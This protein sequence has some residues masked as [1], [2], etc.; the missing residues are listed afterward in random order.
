MSRPL[1]CRRDADAI[2]R[3][4]PSKWT[5][6]WRK[7]RDRSSRPCFV[8]RWSA[9]PGSR[10][11]LRRAAIRALPLKYQ[12]CPTDQSSPFVRGYLSRLPV[13][14][15]GPAARRG[16]CQTDG[17]ARQP[18]RCPRG[19]VF[20]DRRYHGI[21][22]QRDQMA[23]SSFGLL[24][25]IRSNKYMNLSGKVSIAGLLRPLWT[26]GLAERKGFEPSIHLSSVAVRN[27]SH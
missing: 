13:G 7:G 23:P 17:A 10:R 4:S 19:D 20:S 11:S 21:V 2:F 15:Y 12:Q 9:A 14:F 24:R 8:S 5:V 3:N 1:T 27:R 6:C 26:G 25:K 18:I 22:A 16:G